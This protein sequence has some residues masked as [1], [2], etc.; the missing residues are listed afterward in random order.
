MTRL[1]WLPSP[2]SGGA[3]V[4]AWIILLWPAV[5]R[6]TGMILRDE[7][8]DAVTK[9]PNSVIAWAAGTAYA[10]FVGYGF[11]SVIGKRLE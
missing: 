9:A 3:K 6:L 8:V 11:A 10:V 5:P 7:I 2:A 1:A 4:F